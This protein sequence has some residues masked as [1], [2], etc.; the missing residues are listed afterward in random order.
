MNVPKETAETWRESLLAALPLLLFAGLNA[1]KL[2]VR[3]IEPFSS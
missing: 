1:S 3:P 2:E